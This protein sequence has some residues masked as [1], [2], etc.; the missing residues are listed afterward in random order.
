M[1]K[2]KF[3]N[4]NRNELLDKDAR[5]GKYALVSN[6]IIDFPL[7]FDRNNETIK[8][9]I[10]QLIFCSVNTQEAGLLRLSIEAK[11]MDYLLKTKNKINEYMYAQNEFRLADKRT[12][13]FLRNKYDYLG[14]INTGCGY[15]FGDGSICGEFYCYSDYVWVQ[16]GLCNVYFGGSL[17]GIT[18][19]YLFP[20][21]T[22]I[23]G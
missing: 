20:F 3:V 11:F 7:D 16:E 22:T 18:F 21:R 17:G 2:N 6:S 19:F 4:F 13:N 10:R 23:I 1:L 5:A 15:R 8:I 14:Q 12:V 9:F